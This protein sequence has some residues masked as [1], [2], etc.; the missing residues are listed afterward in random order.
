M[1]EI[2]YDLLDTR[3]SLGYVTDY[4]YKYGSDTATGL[5][6]PDVHYDILL[7]MFRNDPVLS[8][9]ISITV[10]ATTNNSFKFIGDNKRLVD[11]TTK[12]FFNKFDFDRILDN[13]IYSLLIYGDAFLE[14]REENGQVTELHPL[15]TREMDIIY[16]KHGEIESYIQVPP[17]MP[18]KKI[19]F[20]PE[21][22][23]H[24][25]R[26]WIGSRIYSYSPLEPVARSYSTNVYAHNYL[27]QIFENLP[28]K[29][30]Y[31][32]NESN[33]ENRQELR[34]NLRR[35]KTNP[36]EDLIIKSQNKDGFDFKE[37]Q[38]K[39]DEGLSKVIDGLTKEVLMVTRVPPI[40]IGLIQ[41]DNRST[42]EALIYPFEL[43]V[44]R[45]QRN[46]SSDI[47]KFLLP[48][49]N[50]KNVEF[51]FNPIAFSSETSVLDIASK[52]KAIGLEPGEEEGEHPIVHYLKE[53]GIQIPEGTKIPSA[54]EMM[55]R[56]KEMNPQDPKIQDDTAPSRQRMDKSTT[57]MTSN[58]NDKGASAKGKEKLDKSKSKVS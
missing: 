42:G 37:F 56:Q 50:L 16:S 5:K 1:A 51:K 12:L 13:I 17:G 38:V 45:I 54:E 46:V 10:D 53:K 3:A 22:V 47:N 32:L 57:K 14:V 15:E 43:N 25:R 34:A 28:P 21:N 49:L 44:R 40:W 33:D 39:F 29:L 8:T 18:N 55:E 48:R 11:E 30:I 20:I 19:V 4:S 7:D 6:P 41:G 36:R 27:R 23:I 9:A 31:I 52:M 58:L 24:F 26:T 35:V 2:I